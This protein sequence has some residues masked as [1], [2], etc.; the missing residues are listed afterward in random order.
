MP[1]AYEYRMNIA[2][3]SSIVL[4][5]RTPHTKKSRAVFNLQ[6]GVIHYCETSVASTCVYNSE[7]QIIEA[8]NL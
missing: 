6:T 8:R 4:G 5:T 7:R 1:A 2:P 3:I